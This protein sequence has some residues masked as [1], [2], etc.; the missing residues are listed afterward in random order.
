IFYRPVKR[1]SAQRNPGP[2]RETPVWE[3]M[4][5]V[6]MEAMTLPDPGNILMFLPGTHEIRKTIELLESGS[7]TRGWD[8]FPLHS[9][10]PPSAQDAAIA[11]GPRP[12]IIVATN[13]AE[14]SLTI[15]G[16]RTVIDSGLARIAAYDP[17]RAINTLLIKPIS[18]A[19][20]DQRAGRAGR[21][22][23]GRA[24]R[25]WSQSDHARREEFE[26]P[27]VHRVDLA[28]AI[29]WLKASGVSD[30]QSFRWYDSP[31]ELALQ[32]AEGL[33]HDLGATSS[34]GAITSVGEWMASLPLEPR[35]SRL[36]LAGKQFG[37]VSET[38]FIAA[39]M[40]GEGLFSNKR[41]GVS[42]K[43]F[44]HPDDPT[45]FAGE[46]RAFEAALAMDFDPRRCGAMGI[47]A[48]GA[49][50]VAKNLERLKSIAK[51]HGWPWQEV[52]FIA[53]REAVGHAMLAAFS[54]QLAIRF[55]QGTMAC[56]MVGKRRGKLDDSSCSKKATAFVAAEITEVEARELITH[57]RRTTAIDLS[58]LA[59]MF[60]DEVAESVGAAWDA[61]RKRVVSR[62]ETRFRDLVLETRETDHGVNLDQ[63]AE[64]LATQVMAGELTL[65]HWDHKVSQWTDR[66]DLINRAM[67][68][69]EMPSW[70][71]ADRAAAIAQICYGAT[72]Y[73]EIKEA[74]VW[75]VLRQ[76]LSVPQH[77]A[78]D[79]YCPE[80]ITL[81]NGESA[82]LIYQT[83][84]APMIC[85]RVSKLFGVWETPRICGGRVP[86]LVQILTPGQ[87]P[88]QTTQDMSS[89]WS[90]GYPQ[91]KKELGGR[92][93][94]HPWPDDPRT[95][96]GS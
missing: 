6:C 27:E 68:E 72:S 12:K 56:R 8:V 37:C 10:L 63:A 41:G 36:M 26:A 34:G 61:A 53:Q 78:L 59:N 51:R 42:R 39:V 57:L 21:T 66:L 20:A 71:D 3:S 95:F 44:I 46:W 49:R 81:A 33:L 9:S 94:K 17:R 96:S 82:K 60:P 83:N 69:M 70:T 23:P 18:Q 5:H 64:I 75:R 52:D 58:W 90:S 14:T 1:P 24:F 47:L 93:P 88:W 4:V 91:M 84:S 85:V 29:L 31:K 7:L 73:K 30:P 76:W 54:D 86:L 48:R 25:L 87:K 74:D 45:D 32:R 11:P 19:A 79:G 55:N 28:S 22:A 50:D 35:Y 13:A 15:E 16:V 92:Y 43:D 77:A 89:F 40:Q 38:T 62:H 67:P 2:P 80:K 65:K